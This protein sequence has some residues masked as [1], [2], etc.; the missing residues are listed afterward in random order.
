M[1]KDLVDFTDK[2]IK[3]LILRKQKTKKKN[4]KKI[5]IL[6]ELEMRFDR[7]SLEEIMGQENDLNF[8]VV[9][10]P[11]SFTRR[12]QDLEGFLTMVELAMESKPNQF[13]DERSKVRFLMSCMLG[14]SLE[15]GFLPM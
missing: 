5:F 6:K 2:I 11:P 1:D 13:Q 8:G 9:N 14:K 7:L 4:R 3:L 10:K 15:W 12:N